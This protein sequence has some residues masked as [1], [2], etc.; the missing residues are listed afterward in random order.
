MTAEQATIVLQTAVNVALTVMIVLQHRSFM[1]ELQTL[2]D[3]AMSGS[4]RE[5]QRVLAPPPPRPAVTDPAPPESFL[6]LKEIAPF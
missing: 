3:K 1:K 6:T 5:Y 4:F 2:T